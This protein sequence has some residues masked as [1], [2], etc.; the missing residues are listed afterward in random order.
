MPRLGPILLLTLAACSPAPRSLPTPSLSAPPAPATA[1]IRDLA[2]TIRWTS[3]AHEALAAHV[4][5]ELLAPDGST[6][7][8]C[9][10]TRTSTFEAGCRTSMLSTG[11]A[12]LAIALPDELGG[13]ERSRLVV[14]LDAADRKLA[15]AM[16]IA[17]AEGMQA[18][19]DNVEIHR[20][21]PAPQRLSL[22]RAWTPAPKE[23]P[24]YL[25][26]NGTEET[27]THASSWVEAV[28]TH[29]HWLCFTCG[30]PWRPFP[31]LV[32]GTTTAV[33]L[34]C[35][36]GVYPPNGTGPHH[37]FV[38]RLRGEPRPVTVPTAGWP[39]RPPAIV[40]RA[41]Y[42]LTSDFTLP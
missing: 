18:Y 8:R 2:I 31:S 29:Q 23:L 4:V 22:Q 5:P 19:V 10:P 6:V 3:L 7:A 34:P 37:R 13:P 16:W 1:T 15:I 33:G 32:P 27:L 20:D 36:Y 39:V 24:R 26:V 25:V 11:V 41:I 40:E 28:P 42:E 12:A 38:T 35:S 21:R 14:P 30:G 9:P 17:G